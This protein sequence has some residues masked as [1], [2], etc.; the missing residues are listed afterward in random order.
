M[1]ARAIIHG[2]VLRRGSEGRWIY[3]V[4]LLGY[5][6]VAFGAT[7]YAAVLGQ[8]YLSAFAVFLVPALIAYVQ[9]R[10][11]TVLGWAALAVPTAPWAAIGIVLFLG[12]MLVGD[13][14]LEAAL[15]ALWL[16]TVSWGFVRYRPFG[17]GR[18]SANEPLQ[19]TA[20]PPSR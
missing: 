6:A 4:W 11:P 18:A 5:C 16:G 3:L 12:S 8:E 1:T 10:C 15:M 14:R 17:R 13:F 19:A 20:A 2:L 9:F 7:A